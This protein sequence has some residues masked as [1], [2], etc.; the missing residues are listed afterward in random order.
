MSS[1]LPTLKWFNDHWNIY[2]LCIDSMYIDSMC[3]E[4][5]RDRQRDRQ[6]EMDKGRRERQR[7][8]EGKS[9]EEERE[10]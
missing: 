9:Q 10:E 5:G 2:L 1:C 3:V 4:G 8:R 6:R 7:V